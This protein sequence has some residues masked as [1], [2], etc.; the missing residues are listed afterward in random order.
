MINHLEAYYLK[1]HDQMNAAL[2][3]V[4]ALFTVISDFHGFF[5][6]KIYRPPHRM[7]SDY[8]FLNDFLKTH[9]PSPSLTPSS[10]LLC[11]GC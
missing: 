11:L 10:M 6:W 8:F 1:T 9:D 2:S 5:I 3:R 4:R 7:P